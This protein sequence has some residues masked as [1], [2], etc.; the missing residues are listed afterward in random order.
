VLDVFRD[1]WL[2]IA[3]LDRCFGAVLKSPS[4]DAGGTSRQIGD[5]P[6]KRQAGIGPGA[7]NLSLPMKRKQLAPVRSVK[8]SAA[9]GCP[10]G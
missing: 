6:R 2:G 3:H 10:A 4:A 7:V 5:A 8:I 1:V 9:A